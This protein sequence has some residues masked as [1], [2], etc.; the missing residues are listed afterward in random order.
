MH[1][2][3]MLLTTSTAICE[4]GSIDIRVWECIRAPEARASLMICTRAIS[5]LRTGTEVL[6]QIAP[7]VSVIFGEYSPVE[8]DLVELGLKIPEPTKINT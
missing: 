1:H 2:K 8:F 6:D 3:I 4:S 7:E 5:A